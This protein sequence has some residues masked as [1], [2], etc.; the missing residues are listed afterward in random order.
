MEEVKFSPETRA[1]LDRLDRIESGIIRLERFVT[2]FESLRDAYRTIGEL[3][4]DIAKRIIAGELAS[5]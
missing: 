5:S 1:I 2:Q 3:K 4:K